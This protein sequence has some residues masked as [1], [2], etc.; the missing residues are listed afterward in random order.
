MGY[1]VKSHHQG[2]DDKRLGFVIFSDQP[3]EKDLATLGGE[4][5]LSN[6]KETTVSLPTATQQADI[7]KINQ[8]NGFSLTFITPCIFA[9]GYLP[10]WIDEASM[11]GK[12][13]DSDISV[14]LKAVAI[15]RW[16][17]VSGWDSLLWQPKAMRKAVSAGSVYWFELVDAIDLPTLQRLAMPLADDRYDQNDGFGMA[18]I[19]P[20]S[21]N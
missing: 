7:D 19:A 3:L 11:T 16:Q 5:R 4:R 18:V 10:S 13:P 17:A 6:F 1:Q 12:L 2:F 14:R 21:F 20:F 8:A 15:D 9:N